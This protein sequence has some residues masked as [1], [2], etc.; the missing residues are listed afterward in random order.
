MNTYCTNSIIFINRKVEKNAKLC[1]E[2]YFYLKVTIFE[3]ECDVYT[4]S[5]LH[6]LHT[7]LCGKYQYKLLSQFDL[8]DVIIA[9]KLQLGI[10]SW[11]VGISGW[12]SGLTID[13]L[14]KDFIV[15]LILP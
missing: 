3:L 12:E 10:K 4:I 2:V 8:C 7:V 11:L 5:K 14:K 6:V 13:R 1:R 15:Q 9:Q